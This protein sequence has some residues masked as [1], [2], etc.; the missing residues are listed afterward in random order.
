MKKVKK[1]LA[2]IAMAAMM[3]GSAFI[4]DSGM[5]ATMNNISITASAAMNTSQ[6]LKVGSRGTQVKYLQI[7]LNVLGYNAGTADGVFGNGTK[8][9]VIRFQRA[10]GLG[11]DGIAGKNTINKLNSVATQLQNNLNS[12]GYK[13]GTADGILGSNSTNAIK[14]FQRK[15]GLTV[16]GIAGSQ[17]LNKINSLKA[18][19]ASKGVQTGV[20][21]ALKK[22]LNFNSAYQS[23]KKILEYT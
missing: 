18:S 3:M 22:K 16:D 2:G 21:T 12:L 8:N 5:N 10:Y 4:P 1:T 17:T 6:T 9:A 11:A 7:N 19:T 23:A 14:S 20:N 15:Y 13:C